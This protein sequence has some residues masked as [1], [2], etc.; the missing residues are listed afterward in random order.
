MRNRDIV[1]RLRPYTSTRTWVQLKALTKQKVIDAFIANEDSLS[2]YELTQLDR[3][4]KYAFRFLK[5]EWL[6][7]RE[8]TFIQ[9]KYLPAF[10]AAINPNL[11]SYTVNQVYEYTLAQGLS[12]ETAL[13]I[14]KKAVSVY[15]GEVV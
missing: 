10:R 13:A 6:R 5:G 15:H 2:E 12:E 3:W 8:D 9:N 11:S 14:Y 1:K 4:G 7:S